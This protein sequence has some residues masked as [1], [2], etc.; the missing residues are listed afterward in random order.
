M[1]LIVIQ[2]V[3]ILVT[4]VIGLAMIF[5]FGAETMSRGSASGG[6]FLFLILLSLVV[7]T[8]VWL[9]VRQLSRLLAAYLETG[10]APARQ[11]KM[12]VAADITA[13][14]PQQIAGSTTTSPNLPPA[15]TIPIEAEQ[16][17][18]KFDEQK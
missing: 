7:V 8:I 11:T 2:S 6:A 1:T 3:T 9:L 17:T 4:I 12:P 18:R 13:D 15:S 5:I 14:A 16:M 10:E